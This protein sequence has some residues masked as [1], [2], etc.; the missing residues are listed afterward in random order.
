MNANDTLDGVSLKRAS[1][2]WWTFVGLLSLVLAGSIASESN[3]VE[4]AALFGRFL[5]T[6]CALLL[7]IWG[8]H[9]ITCWFVDTFAK[10]K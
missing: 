1:A 9:R 8:L 7:S 10:S 2:V 4:L 6:A 5:G 3:T